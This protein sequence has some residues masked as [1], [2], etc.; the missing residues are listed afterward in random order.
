M[1]WKFFTNKRVK[2]KSN[3]F[4]FEVSITIA[5]D[6]GNSIYQINMLLIILNLFFF[7]CEFKPLIS[8]I[9]IMQK[10][11]NKQ[12]KNDNRITIYNNIF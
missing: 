3:I 2:E 11:I 1:H 5:K 4:L 7:Y 8:H 9:I 10:Q 6:I 12:T